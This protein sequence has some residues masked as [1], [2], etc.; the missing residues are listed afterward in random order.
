MNNK[1]CRSSSVTFSSW[2]SGTSSAAV[3]S[4]CATNATR[5]A[6]V[7][8]AVGAAIDD[9]VGV[10]AVPSLAPV[11]VGKITAGD[12]VGV[13]VMVGGVRFSTVAGRVAPGDGVVGSGG[14]VEATKGVVAAVVGTALPFTCT[15]NVRVSTPPA[16]SARRVSVCV[17]SGQIRRCSSGWTIALS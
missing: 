6:G 14:V 15:V 1:Y 11:A 13:S 7:L 4:P 2:L 16:Y 5:S 10:A 3:P 9:A 8:M 17:W 12:G